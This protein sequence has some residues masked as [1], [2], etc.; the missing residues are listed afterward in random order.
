MAVALRDHP[1]DQPKLDPVRLDRVARSL[2]SDTG[3]RGYRLRV[4]LLDRTELLAYAA[5]D[6][7]GP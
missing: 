6:E 3:G 1:I 4:Y 2:Q 7:L 5:P